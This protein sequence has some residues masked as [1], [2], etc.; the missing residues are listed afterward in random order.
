MH[1]HTRAVLAVLVALTAGCGGFGFADIDSSETETVTPVAV[2]D[3]ARGAYPPGVGPTGVTDPAA[4]GWAHANRLENASYTLVVNRTERYRNGTRHSQLRTRVRLAADR[5]YLTDV[6]VRGAGGPVLLGRPPASATFWSDGDRFLRRLTRD[7]RTVYNEYTPP[8]S[9]AGTW[10]YWVRAVALDGRPSRDVSET[11]G[12]FRTETERRSGDPGVVVVGDGLRDDRFRGERVTEPADATLVARVTPD[13]FVRRY[14]VTY[15]ARTDDGT[16]VR[17]T[18]SVRF[19][20]VG[21]TTV[22]RAPWYERAVEG[23]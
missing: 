17:V 7:N 1:P 12:E 13:G 4:L 6:A 16:P 18:R 8:D 10:P 11:V 21:N 14:R 3:D 19:S 20:A 15:A 2:P 9:Y 5:T 23:A 22:E